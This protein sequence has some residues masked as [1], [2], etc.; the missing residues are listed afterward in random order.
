MKRLRDAVKARSEAQRLAEKP[1]LVHTG[2]P[3]A[4]EGVP[5]FAPGLYRFDGTAF[6]PANHELVEMAARVDERDRK[7]GELTAELG[8]ARAD[9]SGLRGQMHTV[10]TEM[11]ELR[12]KHDEKIAELTVERDNARADHRTVRERHQRLDSDLQ[13]V[14]AELAKATDRGSLA[15]QTQEAC[16][17]HVELMDAI[18]CAVEDDPL[19]KAASLIAERDAAREE[20]AALRRRFEA[21]ENVAELIAERDE[22][23][24][25]HAAIQQQLRDAG[26]ELDSVKAQLAGQV[27]A[28]AGWKRQADEDR[29]RAA[30]LL[31]EKDQAVRDVGLLRRTASEAQQELAEIRDA[32]DQGPQAHLPTV[33]QNI[34]QELDD[35][36]ARTHRDGTRMGFQDTGGPDTDMTGRI[37]KETRRISPN[38]VAIAED[39]VAEGKDRNVPD[40]LA[41]P[42]DHPGGEHAH[43]TEKVM[44][45]RFPD[46]GVSLDEA[47]AAGTHGYGPERAGS[48]TTTRESNRTP[49]SE[50]GPEEARSCGWCRATDEG[51]P[52]KP[53]FWRTDWN[54]VE[55]EHGGPQAREGPV[56]HPEPTTIGER[57]YS[58][59][60]EGFWSGWHLTI[61][62]CVRW[63]LNH[64]QAEAEKARRAGA[65][66]HR[67]D[68]GSVMNEYD[69]TVRWTGLDVWRVKAAS[70]EDAVE[71]V[72]ELLPNE[73]SSDVDFE[74]EEIDP[75]QDV[76]EAS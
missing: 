51:W 29:A 72:H 10:R 16:H 69:V 58:L 41:L 30:S 19:A 62:E 7:V 20:H 28:T 63:W 60:D 27:S 39:R 8:T 32:L 70:S 37:L 42:A 33:C 64:Q 75:V 43:L 52:D 11:A 14:K 4:E 40:G 47:R 56:L 54:E 55:C 76:E 49:G 12:E 31:A 15:R 74:A 66:R 9:A 23:K 35:G 22:A 48:D 38:C 61:G 73:P 67:R 13:A 50:E 2:N 45:K 6:A 1:V 34:R 5:L 65:G 21:Q 46:G 24:A 25:G 44:P 68:G 57:K 26:A 3:P 59:H 36:R 17:R 71:K 18:G 53:W